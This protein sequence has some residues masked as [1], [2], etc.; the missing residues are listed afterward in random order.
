MVTGKEEAI[1]KQLLIVDSL[2]GVDSTG[3]AVVSRTNEVKIAKDVGNPYDLFDNKSFDKAFLGANRVCIGH[4]RWG[5]VGGTNRKNAHPF[6]YD[7]ITGVHNGTLKNKY[8]LQDGH[9]FDV[10]SQALYSHISDNGLKDAIGLVEGAWSLVWWDDVEQ[11]LNFLRNEERPMCWTRS[12]DGK[13]LFFASEAWMLYGVLGR[14]GVEHGQV[15]S[16]NED[17]HYS[18]N[19]NNSGEI[20]KPSVVEV[21]GKPVSNVVVYN[22]SFTNKV[23]HTASETT[24]AKQAKSQVRPTLSLVKSNTTTSEAV[25]AAIEVYNAVGHQELEIVGLGT[26]KWGAKYFHML[27][28]NSPTVPIRLYY[29]ERGIPLAED[30]MVNKKIVC[31]VSPIP[32]MEVDTRF[33]KVNAS[34]VN[35]DDLEESDDPVGEAFKKPIYSHINREITV[36]EFHSRYGTCVWCSGYVNPYHKHS[37]MKDGSGGICNE[38]CEDE[39]VMQYSDVAGGVRNS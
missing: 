27:D 28:W 15:E 33:Y 34:S 4:N 8:A 17:W 2:R 21:K 1:F 13:V 5:T 20:T 10:D 6:Q 23:A 3:I 18:F 32:C 30:E 11:T 7:H 31:V 35:W 25:K 26:N 29:Q 14:N 37:L 24:D 16:S 9:K 36:E 19:I 38:C 12:K 39:G 22:G